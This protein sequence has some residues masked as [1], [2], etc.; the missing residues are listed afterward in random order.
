MTD[1][2]LEIVE[3]TE[4]LP[5]EEDNDPNRKTHIINPPMNTHIW[6]P[7]LT[8]KDV[9]DIARLMGYEI[10]A[11]CGYKWVP[12]HNPEEY[13]ACEACIKVAGEIMRG[14]GE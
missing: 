14:A 6:K 5:Y 7:W 13:D 11:L 8:S 9:V 3:D 1:T 12:K 10:V 2:L 4:L